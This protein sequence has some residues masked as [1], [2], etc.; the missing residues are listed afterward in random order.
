MKHQ[1]LLQK[2]ALASV[3]TALSIVIDIMFK[4]IAMSPVFGFPFYAIPIVLGS[5]LLG[6]IF[7]MMMAFIGDFFGVINSGYPYLP[8]FALAALAWGAIPG[9]LMRKHVQPERLMWAIVIS[10]LLASGFNTVAMMVHYSV[11]TALANLP[12]RLLAAMFNGPVMFVLIRDLY[13][14]MAPIYERYA[15]PL[16]HEPTS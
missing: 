16:K 5:I 8:L 13:R 15:I 4:M 10:Y 2:L 1:M 3:L 11:Q 12:L 7:G 14:R 9:I 6:P